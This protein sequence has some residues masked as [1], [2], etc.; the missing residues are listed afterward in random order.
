MLSV[1][2]KVL[3]TLTVDA[4]R[5]EGDMDPFLLA[6]DCADYLVQKGLPFRRA[7]RVVGKIVAHCIEK[8]IPFSALQLST[9]KTF[10]PLLLE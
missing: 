3:S 1:F 6:T 5:M 7:H 9:L 10:S 4:K 2:T 8:N